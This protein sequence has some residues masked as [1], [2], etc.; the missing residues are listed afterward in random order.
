M[1]P[2]PP[3]VMLPLYI[4]GGQ[5]RRL[6]WLIVII[7]VIVA[8]MLFIQV[9][10]GETGGPQVSPRTQRTL[11]ELKVLRT[12]LEW[13]SYHCERYPTTEEGLKA[14]VRNPGISAWRGFYIEFLTPDVW[15]HPYQ[16][17]FTNNTVMLFSM[18]SD[19]VVGT[20]DD[21]ASPD[22]DLKALMERILPE[23]AE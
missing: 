20:A 3:L 9:Q 16:Y 1:P 6:L 17:A 5:P 4:F 8:R 2:R 18:G 22:P 11:E 23:G 7:G 15:S 10:T 21:L 12:A 19:G 14:L 13:F